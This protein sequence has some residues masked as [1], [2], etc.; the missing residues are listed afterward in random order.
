MLKNHKNY[1]NTLNKTIKAAKESHYGEAVAGN[2]SNS[3]DLWKIIFEIANFKS[4]KKTIPTELDT[5][6]NVSRDP[7]V[8]CEELN[9]LF[10]NVAKNLVDN[11]ES[12]LNPKLLTLPRSTSPK[13]SFLFP[14][15]TPFEISSILNNLKSKKLVRKRDI[16]SEFLK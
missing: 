16:N 7:Q 9:T 14:P 4:K 13:N 6:N 11:I 12:P 5:V 8:I 1:C 3:S 10:V 2:K 15:A